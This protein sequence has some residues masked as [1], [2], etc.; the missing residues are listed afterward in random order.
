MLRPC[1]E[2]CGVGKSLRLLGRG[3]ERTA[4]LPAE[5]AHTLTYTHTHTQPTSQLTASM[6]GTT[7][8][9]NRT[10]V[11]V[12]DLGANTMVVVF[13]YRVLKS[14]VTKRRPEWWLSRI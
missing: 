5:P 7:S 2:T 4:D 14:Q 9:I 12:L 3:E 1:G 13:C 11:H 10:R 8:S 6:P